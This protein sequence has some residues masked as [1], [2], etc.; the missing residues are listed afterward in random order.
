M[1]G[2]R[3]EPWLTPMLTLKNEEEKLFKKY[4]VFLPTR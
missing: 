1:I 3:A 4:Y 2:E